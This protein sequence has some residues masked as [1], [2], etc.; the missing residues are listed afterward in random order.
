V[1]EGYLRSVSDIP[2]RKLGFGAV[3]TALTRSYKADLDANLG[4]V[5]AVKAELATNGYE[6]TECRIMDLFTWA[7]AGE[8]SPPWV[9][10]SETRP[11]LTTPS[12]G[13]STRWQS[14]PPTLAFHSTETLGGRL[15]RC[16]PAWGT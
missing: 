7:Y 5:R 9:R 1:I 16:W 2:L 13:R 10:L 15:R 3:G 8:I 12:L 11:S 4:T 14:L 6:L